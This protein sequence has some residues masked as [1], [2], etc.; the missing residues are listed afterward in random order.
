VIGPEL[1]IVGESTRLRRDEPLPARSAIFDGR[2]VRLRGARGEVLG[3]QVIRAGGDDAP[4]AMSLAV[5]GAVVRGWDVDDVHVVRPS[6]SMYGPSRGAGDYPD[7]LRG[8]G[9]AVGTARRDVL[10]DVA[11]ARAAAPGAHTGELRVGDR[12]YPVALT[13]EPIDLAP[14]DASPRVWAYYN[15]RELARGDG[16]AP[17]SADAWAD[18]ERV[19][20]LFRGYG[21]LATPELTLDDAARRAPLVRGARFVPVK[22]PDGRAAIA[23]DARAWAAALAGSGQQ[24]FAIPIDEP[25]TIGAKLAVRVIARWL[26]AAGGG[27]WLAV[28]DGPD[29]LYGGEV[30]VLIAPGAPGS[31]PPERRWTYNGAPPRAGAMIADTDGAALRTWGWIG[32]RN[33]VPLWYVWDAVYWRDRHNAR[34]RRLTRETAPPFDPAR[35]AVTFDDGDDHGN[36]DGVLIYPGG[37]PSLRL[38]ALRRGL[39]D[40]ALLEALAACAG[41]PAADAIA[42][43]LVPRSLGDA[44]PGA[45][46][47]WPTDETAWE[48]GRGEVLDGLLACS[49]RAPSPH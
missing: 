21:V 48:A 32:F 28:T 44:P 13:V 37:L 25:R 10:F 27:V 1:Q 5:D 45:P 14:I 49:S 12:R 15:A 22:L 19:A 33:D 42:A 9:G 20:A 4:V 30:D 36:L 18:E 40:R 29:W 35:D 7:V 8:G 39:E 3:V 2:E 11:I 31:G 16:F 34:R 24:A 41:R 47:V 23:R 17:D 43:R 26:H 38:A 6:T 46:G